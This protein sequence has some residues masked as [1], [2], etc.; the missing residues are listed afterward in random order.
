MPAALRGYEKLVATGI[1]ARRFRGTGL[2]S[3]QPSGIL[4]L[5]TKT[6]TRFRWR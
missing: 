5:S 4:R 3:E 2:A 1:A 6:E